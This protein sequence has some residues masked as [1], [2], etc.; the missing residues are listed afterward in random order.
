MVVI[1]VV[2]IIIIIIT[3]WFFAWFTA[4]RKYCRRAYGWT[5]GS[6]SLKFTKKRRIS[7]EV[8]D[9]SEFRWVCREHRYKMSALYHGGNNRHLH[10]D[11]KWNLT[12]TVIGAV[13]RC[14]SNVSEVLHGRA[15]FLIMLES[16]THLHNNAK[17]QLPRRCHSD[18]TWQ[19]CLCGS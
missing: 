6:V 16:S 12:D 13:A 15:L 4:L 8:I 19:R 2:I 1:V 11:V 3:M 10:Y 14:A 5:A 18:G 7:K 17:C 9:C